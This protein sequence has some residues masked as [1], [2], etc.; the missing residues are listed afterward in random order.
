MTPEGYRKYT[1][2]EIA[3]P[4]IDDAGL[5]HMHGYHGSE[6]MLGD[7]QIAEGTGSYQAP[8]MRR[9]ASLDIEQGERV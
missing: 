4:Y 2:P 8:E 5:E 7:N 9:V 6:E 1:L 3:R